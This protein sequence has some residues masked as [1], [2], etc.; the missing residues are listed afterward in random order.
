MLKSYHAPIMHEHKLTK[1]KMFVKLK[2]WKW[3]LCKSYEMLTRLN[4]LVLTKVQALKEL[5]TKFDLVPYLRNVHRQLGNYLSLV[6]TI[7]KMKE[8]QT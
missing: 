5:W 6:T 3:Y 2:T 4:S 7:N 8:H 1:K